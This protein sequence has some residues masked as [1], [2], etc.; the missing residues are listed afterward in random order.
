MVAIYFS[1]RLI[2]K[3]GVVPSITPQNFY[4][5]FILRSIPTKNTSFVKILWNFVMFLDFLRK[6]TCLFFFFFS[7][8]G[9]VCTGKIFLCFTILVS[10]GQRTTLIEQYNFFFFKM[11]YI[12]DFWGG[13]R[14]ASAPP[15]SPP[16]VLPLHP[17]Q[18]KQTLR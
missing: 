1:V 11:N 12:K 13:V 15:P 18:S 6:K 5:K 9:T 16:L 4:N 2:D 14:G 8:Y 10:E 7:C 17:P 3:S